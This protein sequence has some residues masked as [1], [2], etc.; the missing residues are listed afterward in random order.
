M[1]AWEDQREQTA[2][3][4]YVVRFLDDTGSIKLPLTPAHYTT[5]TAAVR[6]SWR[7]QVHLASAFARG[8]NVTKMNLEAQ[9]WIAD[10]RFV[11][12]LDSSPFFWVLRS[13]FFLIGLFLAFSE[14]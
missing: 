11:A 14:F 5:S 3:G 12:A 10:F 1:V 4:V 6:G 13:R 2:D 9:P 7:L 8:S